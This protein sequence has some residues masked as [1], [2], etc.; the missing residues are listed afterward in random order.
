MGKEET[1]LRTILLQVSVISIIFGIYLILA[2][3][4]IQSGLENYVIGENYWYLE[5]LIPGL[6]IFFAGLYGYMKSR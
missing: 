3:W 5:T 6:V 4:I 1:N 2:Q